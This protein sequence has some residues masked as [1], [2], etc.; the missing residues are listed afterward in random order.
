DVGVRIVFMNREFTVTAER[1]QILDLLLT[2]FEEAVR[3]NRQL[4][5]RERELTHAKAELARYAHA[6]EARLDHVMRSIPDV[7]FSVSADWGDVYYASAA[8][9][10]VFGC[11]P[12]AFGLDHVRGNAHEADRG[13]LDEAST[14][15][16]ASG[17]A[18][19][20]E[21]RLLGAG[22][23]TRWVAGAVVPVAERGAVTRLD[24]VAR[25][26]T[27]R[28]QAE[29]RLRQSELQLRQAQ[30]LE[31]VGRLAG[32]VAHDF[33]NLLT[34][35]MSEADLALAGA[36][37]PQL[38]ETFTDILGAAER[39]A[40]LTRQLLTFSRR[41]VV[42][43][44]VLNVND[45]VLGLDKMLRRVVGERM[46]FDLRL[47]P[48]AANVRIDRGHLEQ[49]LMNLVVNARDAMGEAGGTVLIET[50]HVTREGPDPE[51]H[52]D[53]PPGAYVVLTVTDT[54]TGMT[55]DIRDRIFE[56]FFTT[57]DA[58]RGTGLGLA[59]TYSIV[60]EAGG[61]IGVYTEVGVG[62]T[63]K[64]Y[65]PSLATG[66]AQ[67]AAAQEGSVAGGSE[68][69][70]IVEDQAEVRR[71]AQVILRQLGYTTVTAD[72]ADDAIALLTADDPHVDLLLTDMVLPGT[73]G[74]ELA[75]RVT[76]VRPALRVL[77]MSGYSSEAWGR[78]AGA[79]Q[80]PLLQKPFTPRTLARR[81]REV[82]DAPPE[83]TPAS[84]PR[85]L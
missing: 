6:L 70:L 38:R 69:I 21:L 73:S 40:A 58:S 20:F 85:A 34:V 26:I 57:K 27:E 45:V 25:D 61:T 64:V 30:K 74:I 8:V 63:M 19:A 33:N 2:T 67:P 48:H 1:E 78:H 39:A 44:V 15:A 55:A 16:K 81:V 52:G 79:L 66:D 75:R 84:P 37:G 80:H 71:V 24:G 3:Q 31:A 42:E 68:T 56:P 76:T 60:K 35:I 14:R 36:P 59:T 5:E 17:V 4:H 28:K 32:G 22:G 23:A 82:L 11:P 65:L 13:V 51:A 29:E 47:T 77:F 10:R 7:I 72:G 9:E 53:A 41:E 46:A 18:E 43:P 62:T 83:R 12:G 54:G 50:R 49:V